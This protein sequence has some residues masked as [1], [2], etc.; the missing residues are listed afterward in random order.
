MRTV[1]IA[2]TDAN[3]GPATGP[4]FSAPNGFDFAATSRELGKLDG[5]ASPRGLLELPTNP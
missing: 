2:L 1:E 5:S 4:R 3:G